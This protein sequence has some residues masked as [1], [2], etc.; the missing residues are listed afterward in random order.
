VNNK[1]L[2]QPIKIKEIPLEDRPRE[3]LKQNG[4]SSLSDLELVAILLGTGI[5]GFNALQISE[6]VLEI[7]DKKNTI[8]D[9]EELLTIPG[10][11]EVK[12]MMILA[13]MELFRR[14]WKPLPR[15]VQTAKDVFLAFRIL[16]IESRNIFF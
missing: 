14:K 6:Q 9:L 16:L 2:N 15:R 3:K 12:A 1:Y 10:I 11:G 8:P 5:K 7:L 4:I 13:A